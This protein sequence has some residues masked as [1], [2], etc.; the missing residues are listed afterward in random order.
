MTVDSCL[1]SRGVAKLYARTVPENSG[2]FI[3]PQTDSAVSV[4]SSENEE[5]VGVL[6]LLLTSQ[7]DR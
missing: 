3:E 1:I 7:V 6:L 2:K 5:Q 4:C